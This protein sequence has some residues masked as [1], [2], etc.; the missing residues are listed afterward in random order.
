MKTSD[1]HHNCQ[2]SVGQKPE[3][4]QVHGEGNIERVKDG[5]EKSADESTPSQPKSLGDSQASTDVLESSDKSLKASK[6]DENTQQTKDDSSLLGK[7]LEDSKSASDDGNEKSEPELP[8]NEASG[9]DEVA[10]KTNEKVLNEEKL[11]QEKEDTSNKEVEAGEEQQEQVKEMDKESDIESKLKSE[12]EISTKKSEEK[13]QSEGK[14]KDV[15]EQIKDGEE[16]SIES[17]QVMKALTSCEKLTET[18]TQE[19]SVQDENTKS[20][21]DKGGKAMEIDD[22]KF[23]DK[24]VKQE[25]VPLERQEELQKQDVED[26]SD[27]SSSGN[28]E[29]SE[30]ENAGIKVEKVNSP[31]VIML[32]DDDD[33]SPVILKNKRKLPSGEMRSSL[34]K[35]I[36][37]LQN[38]LRNEEAT[39][40]LLKKLRQSQVTPVQEPV[41][42]PTGHKIQAQHHPSSQHHSHHQQ[43]QS[44]RHNGPP[45]LVKGNQQNHRNVHSVSQHSHGR[46]GQQVNNVSH[47]SHQ[48]GPPP[49]VMT[50][51]SGNNQSGQV[52]QHGARANQSQNLSRNVP[53]NRNHHQHHQQQQQLHQQLQQQQQ[54][55]QIL[56]KQ[57]PPPQPPPQ[58]TQTPAQRQ[59]AA[60]QALRKQL[61]KTLLQIPPPKPPPPEMN[62]IPSLACPDFV[63]LL[64]LEEVVNHMID[65]QLIARGQK[66]P[67][68]R[69]VCTPFTCVQCGSDFTPVWKREKPGSK[70]VI[71]EHCVTSNQKKALKQEHTNRLKSAFVKALQ[72]EQEIERMQATAA[73]SIPNTQ[74]QQQQASSSNSSHPQIH[75]SN[76]SMMSAA[77]AAAAAAS[78]AAAAAAAANFRPSAE[79]LRQHHMLQQAQLRA[80]QPLGLQSFSHRAPFPYNLP[81]AKQQ[82][83][84]RQYLLDMIPR[85]SM[86]WKQ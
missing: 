75:H 72:Q 14:V 78:A 76:A 85:G 58:D 25:T 43:Q 32:S 73:P 65:Y 40:V 63:L 83:L 66:S 60:K 22:A 12:N 6:E 50:P 3:N 52:A 59:A 37:S 29:S 49:L 33:D 81:Y 77:S 5:E 51:R 21:A 2:E 57:A 11:N 48:Q 41:P 18:A 36:K 15:E 80:G 38:K 30:K 28:S 82:D 1:G 9:I 44:M 55:E 47:R 45:P 8:Q 17:A 7:T 64:G 53:N 62:F 67:D 24:D 19:V 70:N 71:C 42:P 74:P 86:S 46:G 23:I 31:D 26:Q 68:E 79:Q 69:F 39:L 34:V 84:Q 10:N 56:Q 13:D 16:K 54:R 4:E 20:I 27:R 61:E 35:K